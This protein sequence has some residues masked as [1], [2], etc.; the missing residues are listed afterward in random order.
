MTTTA[1]IDPTAIAAASDLASR[2]AA[3]EFVPTSLR[4]RPEAVV[5]CVLKGAELG[6]GPMQ[7]LA[8]IDV[9]EGRP[10]I[11]A[12]LMRALILRAGHDVWPEE[13]TN[14]RATVCGRRVGEERTVKA[15]WTLDDAKQ[16]NLAG[17]PNW[18]RYPR[19]MLFARATA[20]LARQL[21]ADVLGGI[22]AVEEL[23]EDGTITVLPGSGPDAAPAQ[24]PAQRR[25]L[26]RSPAPAPPTVIDSPAAGT[27]QGAPEP[28]T[29]T[30]DPS[31]APAAPQ[32][33]PQRAVVNGLPNPGGTQ[34]APAEGDPETLGSHAQKIAMQARE[35]GLERA[36]V[37]NASTGGRKRSARALTDGEGQSVLELLRNLKLGTITLSEE[38]DQGV[39]HVLDVEP[40]PP[41]DID[42]DAVRQR[43]ADLL[44]RVP[45]DRRRELVVAAGW[46]SG[47]A[48]ASLLGRLDQDALVQLLEV[49]EQALGDDDGEPA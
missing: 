10:A 48:V 31:P 21:F 22:P 42:L 23:D 13:V 45:K 26:S 12:E 17:R 41:L 8:T 7:A 1:L 49:T 28:A 33:P 20:E 4:N 29:P 37:I 14:T 11:R 6:I 25:R 32:G 15:T 18:Q 34:P 43:L 46:Q 36:D 35:L 3:T 39:V 24:T 44:P 5:A 30:P 19:A 16:A 9:I 38:D 47:E 2:I 27:A 40:P